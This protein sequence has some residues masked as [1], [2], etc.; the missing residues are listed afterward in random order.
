M[1]FFSQL[2][3]YACPALQHIHAY[4]LPHPA[5]VGYWVVLHGSR[6]LAPTP[7]GEGHAGDSAQNPRYTE[8]PSSLRDGGNSLFLVH[9]LCSVSPCYRFSYTHDYARRGEN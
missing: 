5:D 4:F 1:H 2:D 6:H 3:W 8:I 9:F 7:V